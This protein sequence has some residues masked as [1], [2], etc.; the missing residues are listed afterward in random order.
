MSG[1]LVHWKWSGSKCVILIFV[2]ILLSSSS[3]SSSFSSSSFSSSY[4]SSFSSSSSSPRK[5]SVSIQLDN[6][7]EE[8]QAELRK[9][10]EL[11]ATEKQKTLDRQEMLEQIAQRERQET[12]DVST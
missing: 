1:S 11:V 4:S 12:F 2:S 6:H 9:W 8:Q 3:F 10:T 7:K 5:H